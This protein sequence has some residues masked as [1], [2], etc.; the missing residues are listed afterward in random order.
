VASAEPTDEQLERLVVRALAAV[1]ALVLAGGVATAAVRLTEGD[2]GEEAA[3]VVVGAGV[4]SAGRGPAPGTALPAYV[5]DRAAALA[6]LA[7]APRRAAIVS[8]E[9]YRERE[10][11]LEATTGLERRALLI[12][13][14][15]GRSV[16]VPVDADLDEVVARQRRDAAAE[17]AAIEDLLPTV[18]DRDFRRQYEADLERLEA[19]LAGPADVEAIVHGVVVTGTGDALRRTARVPGVRLVDPD[20]SS[21]LRP[22]ERVRAG[23]P[24]TRPA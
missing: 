17:K 9:T 2:T 13:L 4:L 21:G 22:E 8:F 11:A 7:G 14:P 18:T 10:A 3:D 20:A 5:R 23:E 24:P 12:A 16:E 6:A 19:L 1:V 15:G